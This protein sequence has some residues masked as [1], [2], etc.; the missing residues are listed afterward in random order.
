MAK[1]A[2]VEMDKSQQ[3]ASR[4]PHSSAFI[5]QALGSVWLQRSPAGFTALLSR[6]QNTFIFGLKT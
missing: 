3:L 2:V 1:G 5:L 6:P 4:A